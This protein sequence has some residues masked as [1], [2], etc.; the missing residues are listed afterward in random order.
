PDTFVDVDHNLNSAINKI[1]EVL[2]DSAASP[3]FVD[4]LRRR[5]CSYIASV[6]GAIPPPTQLAEEV[7]STKPKTR[8]M[9]LFYGLIIGAVVVTVGTLALWK[10]AFRTPRAPRVLRYT[11]LTN[12][13]Q[14][15]SGFMATDGSR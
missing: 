7:P 2:G 4:T 5:G 6:Y 1:R 3:R 9:P 8:G 15:K 10:T 13:G 14:V 11:P 12:D